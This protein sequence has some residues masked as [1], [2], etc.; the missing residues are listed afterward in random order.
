MNKTV[1]YSLCVKMNKTV[2]YSLGLKMVVRMFVPSRV[3]GDLSAGLTILKSKH[4][5]EESE[6]GL[7]TCMLSCVS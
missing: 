6:N 7:C 4:L 1:S 3:G 2:S 5:L